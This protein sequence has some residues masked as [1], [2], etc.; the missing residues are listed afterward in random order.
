MKIVEVESLEKVYKERDIFKK[1]K[2]SD[3]IKKGIFDVS[4]YVEEG[5]I[6]SIIGLNGAGKTTIMKCLLGLVDYDKGKIDIF[7]KSNLDKNSKKNIG[8][9]PEISYYPK[10]IKLGVLMEYYAELL[11]LED[12]KRAIEEALSKVGLFDLINTKLEEFSKGM[13]QK[14]GI[15]QSILNKPKL[16]CLDEPMSGLDPVA[17][18]EVI[19]LLKEM[20]REGTTIFLNTHILNDIE[21]I[22]D[23]G[24]IVHKGKIIDGFNLEEF[25]KGELSLEDYFRE[26][27]K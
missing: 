9:L 16:L 21:K 13:L 14:V 23:R 2:K 10:S 5:E 3:N 12:K 8:Y 17:R 4:F 24:I 26:K 25:R 15:A 20:K 11:E 19:E 1:L 27:I 7:Q 22:G 18:S 6:F